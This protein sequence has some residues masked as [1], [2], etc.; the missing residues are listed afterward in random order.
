M[1]NKHFRNDQNNDL[2]GLN[3]SPVKVRLSGYRGARPYD[4]WVL[5]TKGEIGVDLAM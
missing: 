4:F 5:T 2:E 1:M 3:C